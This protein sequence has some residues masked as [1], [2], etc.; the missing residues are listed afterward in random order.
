MTTITTNRIVVPESVEGADAADFRA[1]FDVF[2][3]ALEADLGSEHLRMAPAEEL[4][5]WH[6]GQYRTFVGY[7]AKIEGRPVGSMQITFAHEEGA[8][9]LNVDILALPGF[10]GLG[11]EEAL[12]EDLLA[13]ARAQERTILQTYS[14]HRPDTDHVRLASPTGFGE[15]PADANALFFRDNGFT[16]EQVERNS[17][18]DMTG[19]F[20]AVERM[21]DEAVA[22][23]G[24]DYRLVEWIDATPERWRE[25]YAYIRSRMS[26]DVPMAGAVWTDEVWDAERVIARDQRNLDSGF[27]ISVAAIEHV[28]SG[29][30][31]A[32]SELAL[33][34]EPSA[35]SH[36]W[37]T[38]VMREHR[39]HRLGTI[40][41][42]ANL[43]RWR[44]IAPLSPLISTFNAEENRHM[45][46]VNE[47]I[48]FTTLTV[49]GLW[50]RVLKG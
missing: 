34:Q 3:T 17:T 6:D 19:S 18:F 24:G 39:G 26:T 23:A 44:E 1:L 29:A 30:I 10:R 2:N 11:V 47:E 50:K 28:P 8:E 38:L 25:S 14:I 48:G 32:F 40:V 7:L 37:G 12:L 13:E 35:P 22:V 4:P 43:L 41:K 45:L 33:G 15:I 21:L 9:E 5:L 16:L 42:C 27:T 49:C 20:T 36:Q 46:D 31:V